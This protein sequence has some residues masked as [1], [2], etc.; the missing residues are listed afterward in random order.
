MDDWESQYASQCLVATKPGGYLLPGAE[1]HT[2]SVSTCEVRCNARLMQLDGIDEV[3][4]I[5]IQCRADEHRV[6]P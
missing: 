5:P 2:P 6:C 4:L 1:L 3:T